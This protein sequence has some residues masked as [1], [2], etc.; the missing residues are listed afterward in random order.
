MDEIGAVMA[1]TLDAFNESILADVDVAAGI[2][3]DRARKL[4]LG[5]V[6]PVFSPLREEFSLGIEVIHAR[7]MRFDHNDVAIAILDHA[8]W[9][10]FVGLRHLPGEEVFPVGR[11]FLNAAG[12]IDNVEI[13]IT[14]DGNGTRLVEFACARSARTDHIYSGKKT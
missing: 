12:E 4:E 10:A 5:N 1:E 2:N 8:L 3:R 7:I 9:F 6:G 14:I 13:V 11:K